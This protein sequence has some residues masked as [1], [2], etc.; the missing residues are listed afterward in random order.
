MVSL[1]SSAHLSENLCFI[2]YFSIAVDQMDQFGTKLSHS[3]SAA[4]FL[5]WFPGGEAARESDLSSLFI[6][7]P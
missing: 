5:P 7:D 4:T 2:C 6:I 3:S 1:A